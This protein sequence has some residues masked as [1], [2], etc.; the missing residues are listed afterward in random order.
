[1]RI[2]LSVGSW[3]F[4]TRLW[5]SPILFSCLDSDMLAASFLFDRV[6]RSES[7]R[8]W[9]DGQEQRIRKQARSDWREIFHPATG[10]LCVDGPEG[11][12]PARKRYVR[13]YEGLC[14]D[15]ELKSFLS[16]IRPETS[17]NAKLHAVL[18]LM[19]EH[20][21]ETRQGVMINPNFLSRSWTPSRRGRLSNS[22]RVTD[23][24]RRGSAVWGGGR[25]PPSLFCALGVGIDLVRSR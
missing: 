4:A 1:M 18:H 13:K 2:G 23:S 12:R 11:S 5:S 7:R 19:E 24:R 20:K 8:E 21:D 6:Y 14:R 17:M 10:A 3:L 9:E 22:K 25:R 16:R 15:Q